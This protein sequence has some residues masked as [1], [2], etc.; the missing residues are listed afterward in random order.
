MRLRNS[1]QFPRPMIKE[2]EEDFNSSF[3]VDIA[4]VTKEK[5]I[6]L[7][8]TID[9]NSK[10]FTEHCLND[11]VKI[12]FHLY[13]QNI[14]YREFREV[15]IG[16][17]EGVIELSRDEVFNKIDITPIIVANRDFEVYCLDEIKDDDNYRVKKGMILGY[18]ETFELEVDY[19]KTSMNDIVV[20]KPVDDEHQSH[21]I[22]IGNKVVYYMT[23]EEYNAFDSLYSSEKEHDK[24]IVKLV[25]NAINTRLLYQLE[26]SKQNGD[27]DEF[28]SSRV[29]DYLK[30]QFSYKF[31]N[32]D[33]M[34]IGSDEINKYAIELSE[35]SFIDISMDGDEYDIE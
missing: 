33:I 19:S 25:H 3:R 31:P 35:I 20:V 18:V 26:E 17:L 9:I 29:F 24:R 21:I 30:Y 13:A 6:E 15:K 5:S 14:M 16:E 10:L 4:I 11:D 12:G 2:I 34:S 27:E 28:L 32:I 8:Y 7:H 23:K 1:D 22:E